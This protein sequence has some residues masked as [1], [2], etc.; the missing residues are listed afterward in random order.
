LNFTSTFAIPC[1]LS[2]LHLID[3]ISQPLQP[4]RS[5]VDRIDATES[6]SS[7]C[8]RHQRDASATG[9]ALDVAQP[10]QMFAHTYI[11]ARRIH[12]QVC[13]FVSN[14]SP[15]RKTPSM[16]TYISL[17]AGEMSRDTNGSS[18]SRP[19]NTG[20]GKTQYRLIEYV[21]DLDRYCPGGYHPLKI[22]DDLDDGR[23]R[24]VDK[25]GYGGYSTIWLARDL[26]GAR[27]VAVKAIT[28]DSSSCTPEASLLY[29]LGKSSS[30][31]GGEIIPPFLDEF[32]VTDSNGKHKC[33]VT[34][35]AQM[36]LFDAREASTFGVFQPKVAQ[37]IIAQLIRGVAFL[38]SNNIV[39]GG[40]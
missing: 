24:L 30:T 13:T 26:R 35:P 27:Y 33:I 31:L 15:V 34:P 39:H 3:R 2:V 1:F 9:P 36:S 22:G 23:Y 32:W 10:P 17:K 8:Q 7:S 29:S 20:P 16:S 12:K 4:P 11:N 19:S 25:L 37:S 14:L 38:H 21:E 40:M 6:G 28:A 18:G 5:G